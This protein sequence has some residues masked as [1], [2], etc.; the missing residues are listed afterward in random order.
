MLCIKP[1]TD[2]TLTCYEPES[3]V[4]GV[5]WDGDLRFSSLQSSANHGSAGC[6][7]N[8]RSSVPVWCFSR[9]SKSQCLVALTH[10]EQHWATWPETHQRG[11]LVCFLGVF[12]H[13][14]FVE[15]CC[16]DK[17]LCCQKTFWTWSRNNRLGRPPHSL[18]DPPA[19]FCVW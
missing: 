18:Y 9:T 11:K 8:T 19:L 17:E 14:F 5:F 6:H 2:G 13:H 4:C 10:I 7:G 15:E 16:W 1:K 3:R 12:S